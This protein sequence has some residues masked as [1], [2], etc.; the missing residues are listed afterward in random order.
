MKFEVGRVGGQTQRITSMFKTFKSIAGAAIILATIATAAAQAK[1]I[2]TDTPKTETVVV[3][4]VAKA[5][6]QAPYFWLV[7]GVGF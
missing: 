7:L 1:Q 5:Q 6:T 2:A 3:Q 4:K